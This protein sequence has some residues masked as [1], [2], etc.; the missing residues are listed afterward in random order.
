VVPVDRQGHRQMA[1][2]IAAAVKGIDPR[3][4]PAL[5]DSGRVDSV[6]NAHVR[7]GGADLPPFSALI[8]TVRVW[9]EN[10]DLSPW[11]EPSELTAGPFCS[12]DWTGQWIGIPP[13]HAARL[14]FTVPEVPV[15]A[16]L[17]FAGHGLLRVVLN[18]FTVNPDSQEPS[19]T[20]LSRSVSR[21]YD[22]TDQL[23]VGDQVLALVA[24]IGHYA[25]ALTDVRAIAQLV[26][27]NA[28]GQ[29]T[30]VG[31][32]KD[33]KTGPTSVIHD[34]PFRL[35]ERDA[36]RSDS[37]TDPGFPTDDWE[38]VSVLHPEIAVTP[39]AGP[40]VIVVEE[41][42]GRRMRPD[43]LVFD[44]G[45]NVAA[46]SRVSIGDAR[47][48][49]RVVVVHGEKIGRDGYVDTLNIRLPWDRD[50]ERQL[51]ALT[52][53]E[54]RNVV[55]PWF[56]VHGFRY[57]EVRGLPA[58]AE[59][60]VTA[61]VLHSDL[62]QTGE[63]SSDDPLLDQLVAMAV[64]GQRNNTHAHPEDCPT[65]EQAGWTG[66]ASASAEAAF[67]HLDMSG[68]Y[69]HWLGDVV[70]DQR[71]DGGIL[72]VSPELLGE[73][74]LQPADPVWG[75]AMTELP[76]QQW[77]SNGDLDLVAENLTAMRNWCDWQVGTVEDGVVRRTAISFGADWLAPER[78]PAVLLQTAAVLVSLRAL[79][80]MEAGLG[81]ERE[82][83]RRRAQADEL[84]TSAQN[85][86]GDPATGNWANGSQGALARAVASGLADP[87]QERSALDR[88]RA[89]MHSRGDRVSTGFSATQSL[90][91]VLGRSADGNEALL[92]AVHQGEQPGIGSMLVDGPGT[93]WET[94]WIDDQNA[95]VASL[96][97]IGL[98]APFAAWAWTAVAG[99]TPESPGWRRFRIAP[100]LIGPIRQVSFSRR[101]VRGL[102]RFEATVTGGELSATVAVPTGTTAV[103]A[104][105][106]E[107]LLV[108]GRSPEEHAFARWDGTDLLLDPG[109]YR[110]QTGNV[111][112][113]KAKP[114]IGG[115]DDVPIG[116]GTVTSIFLP[117]ADDDWTV[118]IGQGWSATL[119]P[120]GLRVT[121]PVGTAPNATAEVT[122]SRRD[123]VARRIARA[124][125][126]GGWPTDARAGWIPPDGGA[127]EVISGPY[128]CEP[129][130]HGP[131]PGDVLAIS[132]AS[133]APG[134]SAWTRLV[135]P[136][137]ADLG[138]AEFISAELDLC[139]PDVVGRRVLPTLRVTSADGTE[140][141]ATIRPLPV[142]WN[143][144]SVDVA[145]W[146]GRTSVV[147]LAVGLRWLDEPESAR[148]GYR[149][150]DG[151]ES[152]LH[153]RLGN[154][155]WTSAPRTW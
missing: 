140:R 5:W 52:C 74:E 149:P 82:S 58:D 81:N 87:A 39:D 130:Y 146:P 139:F 122:V 112:R 10:G 64:A 96:D 9:D 1:Y 118:A 113:H 99:L 45:R 28:D 116:V 93:F 11:A 38:A 20:T 48:G 50:Q 71:P 14:T 85:A 117:D 120:G 86:L 132:T 88:I 91:R 155:R 59:V 57:V 150:L 79:A 124:T 121:P 13:T 69:R 46:R 148:G 4:R 105:P 89:D 126:G 2:Q 32:N 115:L 78:T 103:L 95:G 151:A 17:H 30:V 40:P 104:L 15:R 75:A 70:A 35:E 110:L 138:A 16:Y 63:F 60:A 42:E 154:V 97:H 19:S 83:N 66:D 31:T 153:V 107:G 26:L 131:I 145:D 47:E 25:Q 141:D 54:G 7:W 76:W 8:W 90:V 62:E 136:Q 106:G 3:A 65:R 12:D 49:T 108:D 94:W 111:P 41:I 134:Q 21:S 98:A 114:A 22:V 101:T 44:L 18:G 24:G 102:I 36:R 37:W 144:V 27:E 143:R 51:V 53:V 152:A 147:E 77:F 61:R 127:A 129:V 100:W 135:L 119:E 123:R 128:L 67:S 125:V 72:G 55:E 73:L 29:L 84:L 34:V 137:P 43:R 6:E 80:E 109:Q 133:L 92:R 33:W 23:G 142:A 68:V 56:A